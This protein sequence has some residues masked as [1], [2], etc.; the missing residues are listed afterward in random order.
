VPVLTSSRARALLLLWRSSR[1]LSALAGV[2]VLAEGA[3]PVLVLVAMGRVTGAIPGAVVFGLSSSQGHT[4]LINLAEAGGVYALSLMR[5]PLED[6]LTA[7]AT[8]RVEAEMQRR[9]VQAVCAPVGIE[10]LEDQEVLDRLASARGELLGGQPSGASMA[11]IS[12]LGDRFTGL[13]ACVVL[14]T[15][16]WWLGLAVFVVWRVIRRPLG[17]RLRTAAMRVRTAGPPLRRSWY[18]LGLA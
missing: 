12:T 6:A 9:L 11:L 3:L 4:L 1:P 5:G 15:F 10:H 7:A 2:F 18:L 17:T 13:L 8:A 14:A 16:R